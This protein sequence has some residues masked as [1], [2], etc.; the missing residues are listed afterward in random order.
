MVNE[1]HSTATSLNPSAPVVTAALSHITS[2][3]RLLILG[4]P[5]ANREDPVSSSPGTG[6]PSTRRFASI[7]TR[8]ASRATS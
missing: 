1:H 3:A 6:I 4:N 5:I 7:T 2:K 8:S